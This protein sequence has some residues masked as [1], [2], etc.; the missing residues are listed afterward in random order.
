MEADER[1]WGTYT[2]FKN[3]RKHK[4]TYPDYVGKGVDLHGTE[5]WVSIW[6]KT[7]NGKKP[8]MYISTKEK[9]EPT[10]EVKETKQEDNLPF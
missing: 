1:Q 9:E 5:C 2:V 3:E 7:P 6:V 4:D 10:K 8:F